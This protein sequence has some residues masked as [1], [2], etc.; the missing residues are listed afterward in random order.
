VSYKVFFRERKSKRGY[1][2]R[3]EM[4]TIVETL[5]FYSSGGE[6]QERKTLI[7]KGGTLI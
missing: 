4:M 3:K 1:R 5:P 6:R 2:P 7:A